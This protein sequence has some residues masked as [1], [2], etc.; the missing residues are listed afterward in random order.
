MQPALYKQEPAADSLLPFLN[1]YKD[2]TCPG[3]LCS[4]NATTNLCSATA[5]D[6]IH[7]AT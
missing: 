5:I 7:S 3:K 2:I 6:I 4:D 1:T